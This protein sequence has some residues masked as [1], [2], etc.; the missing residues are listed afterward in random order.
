MKQDHYYNNESCHELV[1]ITMITNLL[2][3]K[4]TTQGT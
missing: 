2:G 4:K 3:D 1:L